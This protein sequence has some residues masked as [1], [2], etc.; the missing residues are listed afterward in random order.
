MFAK[1]ALIISKF[2]KECWEKR[3]CRFIDWYRAKRQYL[4]YHQKLI[5]LHLLSCCNMQQGKISNDEYNV[6]ETQP[7]YAA[8]SHF[9]WTQKKR[10]DKTFYL[11]SPSNKCFVFLVLRNIIM[12]TLTNKNLTQFLFFCNSEVVLEFAR[13]LLCVITVS[14]GFAA[15]TYEKKMGSGWIYLRLQLGLF[16]QTE[17]RSDPSKQNIH[18]GPFL[19]SSKRSSFQLNFLLKAFRLIW[20]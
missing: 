7:L 3:S 19:H 1:D 20:T 6:Q 9:Q 17:E 8:L 2:T 12:R 13:T 15:S 11:K 5:L 10:K 14:T 18:C 4:D 16:V